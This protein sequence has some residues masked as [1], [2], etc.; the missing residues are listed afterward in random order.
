MAAGISASGPEAVSV[1]WC[2]G[3]GFALSRCECS[4]SGECQRPSLR[5]C[6]DDHFVQVSALQ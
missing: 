1:A 3:R 5:D 2:A 4:L 6:R